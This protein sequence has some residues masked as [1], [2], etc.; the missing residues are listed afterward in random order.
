MVPLALGQSKPAS[1]R[2][3]SLNG[4]LVA[5]AVAFLVSSTTGE[6]EVWMYVDADARAE[7]DAIDDDGV[8]VEFCK[9]E[10]QS[11]NPDRQ[12]SPQNSGPEPQYSY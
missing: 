4:S 12:P 5:L 2:T 3:E 11:P 10:S 7:D 6:V 9:D 1:C 8:T